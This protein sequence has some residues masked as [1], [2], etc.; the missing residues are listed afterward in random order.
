ME[1][2]EAVTE[3]YRVFLLFRPEAG[4][5]SSAVQVCIHF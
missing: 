1:P 3:F 5:G 2:N 4:D